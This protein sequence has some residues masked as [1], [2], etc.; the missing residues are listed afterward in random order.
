MT[1]VI[2]MFAAMSVALTACGSASTTASSST[3]AGAAAQSGPT[4]AAA[5]TAQ[6]T[7]NQFEQTPVKITQTEPLPSAPPKGKTL[8]WLNCDIPTCTNQG[9]GLK[10]AMQAAGWN[11]QQINYQSANPATLT[12]AFQRALMMKPTVVVESGVPPEAGW[13]SVLPAYKAAGIPIITSYLGPTPLTAPIIA[14]VAGPATFQEYAKLVAAWFIA[15]SHGT[16]RALIE[17]ID[18]YPV[19]KAYSDALVADIKQGCAK[20]DISTVLQNSAADAS[21][22]QVVPSIVS[23]LKRDPSLKYVLP[24]DLEFLDA[25]PS[26]MSAAGLHVKVAGQDPDLAELGYL[27]SGQFAMAPSHP[28]VQAGWVMADVAFHY[29][30]GLP[31]PADDN[32]PLPTRVLTSAQ[33]FPTG[34]LQEY[35]TNYQQQFMALWHLG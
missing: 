11:Y 1:V 25:L 7:L 14:N 13:S 22:N 26:A 10:A 19:L 5:A 12:A 23:A 28:E 20:C 35:P 29:A 31:V 3:T 30:M 8:V 17:R 6:K 21:S 33:N 15:D 32:G 16:G 18:S 2:G 4:S 34:Q 27:K 9:A 24:T